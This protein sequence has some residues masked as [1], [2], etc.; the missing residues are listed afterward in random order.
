[1]KRLIKY[2]ASCSIAAF[3]TISAV[4]GDAPPATTLKINSQP[5]GAAVFINRK[6]VGKTP[7]TF[8]GMPVNRYLVVI[9]KS[10][11]ETVRQTVS[12][13]RDREEIIDVRVIFKNEDEKREIRIKAAQKDMSLNLIDSECCC[14]LLQSFPHFAPILCLN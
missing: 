4:A 7:A 6:R 10:G 9:K 5:E 3:M 11:Y 1:M 13:N 8:K 12:I 14:N 2:I